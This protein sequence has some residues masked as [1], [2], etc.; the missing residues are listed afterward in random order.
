MAAPGGFLQSCSRAA[1]IPTAH[2]CTTHRQAQ[3]GWEQGLLRLLS[4]HY[5][6]SLHPP[7]AELMTEPCTTPFG[8]GA[9]AHWPHQEG[10]LPAGRQ[11]AALAARLQPLQPLQAI[12]PVSASPPAQHSFTA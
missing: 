2:I 8:Q 6:L 11:P 3:A 1:G 4:V 10:H 5:A 9:R 12:Q 7:A